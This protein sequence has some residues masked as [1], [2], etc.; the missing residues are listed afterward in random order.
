MKS[1]RS[2]RSSCRVSMVVVAIVKAQFV[3]IVWLSKK[4]ESEFDV[5]SLLHW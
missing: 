3:Q 4:T 2:M 1:C 5:I